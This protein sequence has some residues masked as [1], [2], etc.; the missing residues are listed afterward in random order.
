MA[1]IISLQR[2]LVR[3]IN[4]KYHCNLVLNT[5]QF[6]RKGEPE[7]VTLTKV[8]DTYVDEDGTFVTTPL[9]GSSSSVFVML[10]LRDLL[11]ALDGKEIPRDNENFIRS[12]NY[13]ASRQTIKEM[14]DTYGNL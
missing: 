5:T 1:T 3:G 4:Y 12:K 13:E 8:S 14:V 2:K 7:P 11:C 10:Y 9:Y 6:H